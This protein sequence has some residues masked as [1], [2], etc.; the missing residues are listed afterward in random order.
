MR[1]RTVF[2]YVL[3]LL[4]GVG[5]WAQFHNVR[6]RVDHFWGGGKPWMPAT[7]RASYLKRLDLPAKPAT[8]C[9]KQLHRSIQVLK[10]RGEWARGKGAGPKGHAVLPAPSV[11]SFQTGG[12]Y[13]RGALSRSAHLRALP[14]LAA[15]GNPL[16]GEGKKRGGGLSVR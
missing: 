1:G 5:T 6:W 9:Q 14:G 16:P 2:W 10:E 4:H 13:G 11:A 7:A 12:P 8:R 3:H 15:Q